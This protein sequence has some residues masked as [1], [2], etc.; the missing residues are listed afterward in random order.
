MIIPVENNKIKKIDFVKRLQVGMICDI[1]HKAGGEFGVERNSCARPI[2]T[3]QCSGLEQRLMN[4]T[5][6][7]QVW[8]RAHC[9]SCDE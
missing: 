4:M 8:E 1:V 2:H 9:V 3:P 7:L 5:Y 6:T